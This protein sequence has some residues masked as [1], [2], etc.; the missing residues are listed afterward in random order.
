MSYSKRQRPEMS[1]AE[2]ELW[3]TLIEQ[4]CGL[5][6][7]D[8]RLYYMR[9]RIWD[10]ICRLGLNNY[11]EYYNFIVFNAA[12]SAEW[13]R[14]QERLLNNETSFFRHQ[15]SFSALNDHVIPEIIRR[16]RLE[17]RNVVSAWSAGCSSGQEAYSLAMALS[18]K[19]DSHLWQ[20]AVWGSDISSRQ[21]E[22][23]RH[24]QYRSFEIRLMPD[25]YRDKYMHECKQNGRTSWTVSAP[26]RSLVQFTNFNLF[27]TSDSWLSELDI[28]FCQNVLIY[29]QREQR[30]QIAQQLCQCLAVGGYLFLGPAEVIGLSLAGIKQVRLP[31]SLIYQRT[32]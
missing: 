12:G 5:Y 1:S 28:I 20:I 25:Y 18:D 22:Q 29:F 11:T 27:N 23:A 9:Q 32:R 6:F 17:G 13:E 14:L 15:P 4:R 24:G 10:R 26:V 3:R 31:D 30:M 21:L 16:R 19:I 2:T 7:T 8:G